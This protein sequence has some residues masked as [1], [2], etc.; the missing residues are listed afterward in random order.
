MT[1][2]NLEQNSLA[3]QSLFLEPGLIGSM[4]EKLV[5]NALEEQLSHFLGAQPYERTEKRAG[6]RNGYKPR[7][8]KTAVGQLSF[9]V[10]QTRVPGFQPTVFERYQ[11]SDKALIGAIQEMVIKGVSTREVAAVMEEMAGFEVSAATV[12][13]AMTELDEEIRTFFSRPLK[14][15]EYPYLIVDARYEKI[16]VNG[17]IRS[18][19][20]LIVAGINDE[21]RREILSL[22]IGDSE[23]ADSWGEV[24]SSLKARGVRGV[25]IVISDA[26]AGIQA[27]LAKH[28]QGAGW[29]RCKVHLMRELLAKASWKDYKELSQDLRAIWASSE[30][31]Q[32]LRTAEEVALKWEKKAP[33][34]AQALRSGVEATLEVWSLPEELKRRLNSTN[35]LERVMQ[36]VKK[37]SR[38]VRIFPNEASCRRLVGAI[39][40]EL[41]EKWST[42]KTRYVVL[43]RRE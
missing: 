10:P 34:M 9:R 24:F 6:W 35:M 36:E 23:S 29:Q 14:E 2:D 26:H 3:G 18:Q 22:S 11:R 1:H 38:K 32:C 4:I 41:D 13:H 21:G 15:K 40:I 39:L 27:A 12:S 30:R 25:E 33:R 8:M 17:K 42:E 16:R 20:V 37:R 28:F 43:E 5:Q 7:T 19:A 31:E